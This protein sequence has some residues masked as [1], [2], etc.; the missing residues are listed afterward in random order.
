MLYRFLSK[1]VGDLIYGAIFFK[2]LLDFNLCRINILR[3]ISMQACW[4][5]ILWFLVHVRA[6]CQSSSSPRLELVH[7][8]LS[9][10][11][12]PL[13]PAGVEVLVLSEVGVVRFHIRLV[14]S[15]SESPRVVRSRLASFGVVRSRP[16]LSRVVRSC[17]ESSGVIRSRPEPFGVDRNRS[18]STKSVIA[19]YQAFHIVVFFC[20]SLCMCTLYHDNYLFYLEDLGR[21]K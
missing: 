9:V 7:Y 21:N 6:T 1:S 18:E 8:L 15:R 12:S 20:L 3:N 10:V 4:Q 11:C 19:C 16:V 5:Q 14:Q 2:L 17:P 13:V